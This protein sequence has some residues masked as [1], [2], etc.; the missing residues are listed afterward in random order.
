MQSPIA[1]IEQQTHASDSAA[2]LLQLL[3]G[4]LAHCEARSVKL[5]GRRKLWNNQIQVIERWNA[6]REHTR[7]LWP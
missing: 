6:V 2:P 4:I 7:G 5:D 3:R 1:G